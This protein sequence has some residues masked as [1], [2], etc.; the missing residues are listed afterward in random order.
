MYKRQ[1]YTVDSNGSGTFTGSGQ[2]TIH[3]VYTAQGFYSLDESAQVLTGN[4]NQ[5]NSDAV[6]DIGLPYV[7]GSSTGVGSNSTLFA[8][9]VTPTGTTSSGTLPGIVDVISSGGLFPD[10]TAGG[11]YGSFDLATGH[12]TGTA[13]LANGSTVSIVIQVARHRR[14]FILDMQSTTPYLVDVGEQ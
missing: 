3:F 6:E 4:F 2:K 13:N 5:Q 9:F 7:L 8:G 10:A 14:F 11:T 12:G 1:A